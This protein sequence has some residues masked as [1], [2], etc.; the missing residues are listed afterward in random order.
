VAFNYAASASEGG[1]ATDV[2]CAACVGPT[3]VSFSFAD[4]G[5]NTFNGTQTINGGNL[6]LDAA[7]GKITKNGTDFLHDTGINNTFLG[8]KA[9]SSIG[10]GS[11]NTA[12]GDG[13][14]ASLVTGTDNTS[15]GQNALAVNTS[16]FNTAVGSRALAASTGNSNTAVGKDALISTTTG[17]A[18]TALGASALSGLLTGTQNVAIGASAGSV[19]PSGDRN[20]YISHAGVVAPESDTIRIGAAHTRAFIRGIRGVT[21]GIADAIPVV[22]DSAGQLGTVSSSRRVKEDIRN[23]A[24]A[25]SRLFNLRPVTFRYT[26]AYTDGSKPIQFGL[27]AEEVAEAF[28]ELAVRNAEGQVETV[29]YETL[30]VLLLNELQRQEQR[31]EALERQISGLMTAIEGSSTP[32]T[33]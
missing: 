29:H 26:E 12:L 24:D 5:T 22:V 31:I 19:T 25:S 27:I 32:S 16:L 4:L 30:N 2:A 7:T 8:I 13:A 23:M 1:P 14:L 11:R 9:G 10:S 3:E 20:I 28:P 17:T 6:D 33:R 21:T 15:I 18:N